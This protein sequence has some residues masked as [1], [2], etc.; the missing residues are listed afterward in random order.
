MDITIDK[1][2]NNVPFKLFCRYCEEIFNAKNDRKIPILEKFISK[3]RGSVE[4]NDNLKIVSRLIL[5]EN[6]MSFITYYVCL[7]R[8]ILSSI[9]FTFANTR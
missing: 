8:H 3:Y 7:G 1:S 6:I 2:C 9:T 4:R 5:G